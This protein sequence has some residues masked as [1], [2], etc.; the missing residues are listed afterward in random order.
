MSAYPLRKRK[1]LLYAGSQAGSASS[2]AEART[3]D[4]NPLALRKDSRAPTRFAQNLPARTKLGGWYLHRC[5][6]QTGSWFEHELLVPRAREM[7]AFD[8]FGRQ[9]AKP[10]AKASIAR[11]MA[12]F[13][14]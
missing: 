2:A 8:P 3:C 4:D 11:W 10:T 7:R 1:V 5:G 6:Q 14:S 12:A 13:W 9:W